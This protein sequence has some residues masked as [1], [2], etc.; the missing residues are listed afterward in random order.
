MRKVE[1]KIVTFIITWSFLFWQVMLTLIPS[2][3]AFNRN[4]TIIDFDKFIAEFEAKSCAFLILSTGRTLN[5]RGGEEIFLLCSRDPDPVIT[6]LE[7]DPFTGEALIFQKNAYPATPS[8]YFIALIK[9]PYT[10]SIK[11]LSIYAFPDLGEIGKFFIEVLLK[12]PIFKDNICKIAFSENFFRP[13]TAY[14]SS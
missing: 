8:L 2:L 7:N 3:C 6:Y 12:M 9:V 1:F 5:F 4:C 10:M 11:S 14:S 13:Q